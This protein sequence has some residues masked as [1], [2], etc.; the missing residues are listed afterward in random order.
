MLGVYTQHA[1]IVNHSPKMQHLVG[2]YPQGVEVNLQFQTSGKAAWHYDYHYPRIGM[3]VVWLDYDN[4]VIGQSLAISP[5]LNMSFFR[6]GKKDLNFRIGTGLA[7]FTNKFSIEENPKNTVISSSLNAVLQARFEYDQKISEHF[8]FLTA[9]GLNHY[10]NGAIRKPNLGV[11]LPTLSLGVT[12]HSQPRF[13]PPEAEQKPFEPGIFL[14]VSTSIGMK[15]LTPANPERYL[16][17]SVSLVVGRKANRKSNLLMGLE[18]FYD[19]SLREVQQYDTRLDPNQPLPDIRRVGLYAG[20][21]LILGK[22]SFMTHLGVYLYR[23]Y[24]YHTFYYQR[25][26]LKYQVTDMLFGETDLKVHGGA[27]D[28]IECRVGMRIPFKK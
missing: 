20:H 7:Y 8:S 19:R 11:N 18:G 2:T 5:Y 24:K 10:S 28:V 15:H 27:A 13:T 25:I 17:N 3:S 14:D 1:A 21:E 26:G 22:L 6:S 12:Y 16:V 23:P 4:P 9:L